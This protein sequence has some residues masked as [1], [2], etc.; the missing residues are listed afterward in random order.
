MRPQ[1]VSNNENASAAA[2]MGTNCIPK[3]DGYLNISA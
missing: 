1:P 3:R 2:A